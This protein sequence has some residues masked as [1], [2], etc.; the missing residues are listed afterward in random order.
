MVKKNLI[1]KTVLTFFKFIKRY[2][3]II[4]KKFNKSTFWVKLFIIMA[5]ILIL[6]N[7]YNK[8]LKF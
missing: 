3:N 5:L 1:E 2:S 6:L 4:L 8:N 7:K